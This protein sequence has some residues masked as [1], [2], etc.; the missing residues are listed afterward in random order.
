MA[1]LYAQ[2][3]G[4]VL[5]LLGILGFFTG[6]TVLGLNSD[7]FEDIFHVLAGA[8]ALYAGFGTR[9]AGPAIQYARI[10]GVIYLIV[11]ILGFIIPRL[12]GL[13]PTGYNVLDNIVHLVLGAIGIYV[14]FAAADRTATA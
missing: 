2:V 8:V 7:V 1:R 11:G 3:T 6:N 4:V 12:F 10:F 5:I 14:G 9:D 13:V